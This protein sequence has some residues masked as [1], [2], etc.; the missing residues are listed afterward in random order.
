[1]NQLGQLILP[2]YN[3]VAT[4]AKEDIMAK[5]TETKKIEKFDVTTMESLRPKIVAALDALSKEIGVVFSLGNGKY[6]TKDARFT[7]VLNINDGMTIEERAFH[8]YAPRYQ[9]TEA[10]GDIVLS[11]G[12]EFRVV[13]WN[14]NSH[15]FPLV[16]V[17]VSDGKLFG[18]TSTVLPSQK[19]KAEAWNAK[20]EVWKKKANAEALLKAAEEVPA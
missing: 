9:I 6:C 13:G 7:L 1:M 18:L 16:A 2:Q 14:S 8:E 11:R 10:I 17:R 15:N 3:R 4:N 12:V 20:E 19:A 5:K